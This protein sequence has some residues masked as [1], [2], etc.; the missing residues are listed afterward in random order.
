MSIDRM[1]SHTI[2]VQTAMI[3]TAQRTPLHDSGLHFSLMYDC[4]ACF[5]G[6]WRMFSVSQGRLAVPPATGGAGRPAAC[7]VAVGRGA[8]AGGQQATAVWGALRV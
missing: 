4:L 2:S 6:L 5:A 3:L 7:V 8:L 1:Q